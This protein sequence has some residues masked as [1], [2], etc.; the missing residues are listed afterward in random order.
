MTS[1]PEVLCVG[2]SMA[3]FVP[4]E[5]GPP[6]EVKRWLRTIG[7]AESNVACNLP[8]LGV[9]SGWVSAVGD[10]PFG[11]A[12]VREIAAKGVDV[13][14]CSVDP[15]RPTGLYIKESGAGGSPVRYYRTGS[16]ASA[17]GPEVLDRLDLDGVRVLHLSGIT[18]ALSDSCL[19]L[20]RA[21]L[22]LPRGDRLISFDVNFR[23][24]LW[25]GR[26]PG[27]LAELAGQADIVLTGDDEA[28]RVWGTGDPAD[29]RALL[30]GP[31]TLVVKHGERGATLVEGEPLFSP[32][33]RVDV[34][35]PVGAGDAFAAGFLAATLRGAEPLA[36]LRQGHLQAAVT[37]LTHDD[38]GVP[39]PRP[40]VDSLLQADPDEWRSARLTGEGLVRT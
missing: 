1:G 5:A 29:L 31:R 35:E 39:L 13:S 22:D 40:V 11:R 25:T 21:L 4:A 20:V 26:D 38:V 16:A 18:P 32:A 37:L 8:A 9:S 2:E 12:M 19:A 6:D 23:P 3:M 24:A 36:R 15:L 33:L 30:P 17:M 27:L 28:Q 7:G 34:V 14:A 10:D